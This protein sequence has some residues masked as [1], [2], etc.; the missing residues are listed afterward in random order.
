MGENES[1][2]KKRNLKVY[3]SHKGFPYDKKPVIRLG[4]DYLSEAN[5]KIGDSIEIAAEPGRIV[6][7]KL[8]SNSK[9]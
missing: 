7:T 3:Y 2:V 1:N 4:G 6:I 5:F 8:E 9:S